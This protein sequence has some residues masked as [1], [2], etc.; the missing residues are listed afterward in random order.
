MEEI[1]VLNTKAFLEEPKIENQAR[2]LVPLTPE[3]V[4][5]VVFF[6]ALILVI[7]SETLSYSTLGIAFSFF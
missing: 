7:L 2:F 4:D 1:H 3:K 6:F 5:N